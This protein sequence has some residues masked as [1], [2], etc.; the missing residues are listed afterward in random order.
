[1]IRKYNIRKL[2]PYFSDKIGSAVS[3]ITSADA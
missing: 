2:A 1:M 3:K